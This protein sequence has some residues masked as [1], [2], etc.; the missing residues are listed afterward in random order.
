MRNESPPK[1]V[2]VV[3][4]KISKAVSVLSMLRDPHRQ[5]KFDDD[6]DEWCRCTVV[7]YIVCNGYY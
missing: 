5:V 4:S 6:A 2:R 1:F 3:E 7:M